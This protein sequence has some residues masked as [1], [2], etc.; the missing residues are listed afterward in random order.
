[1]DPLFIPIA[2]FKTIS[3][4]KHSN[5]MKRV[6]LFIV[7]IF[8]FSIATAQKNIAGVW[9]GKLNVGTTSLRL[10]FHLKKDSTGF[11]GSMDSPDQGAKGIGLSKVELK[12]D[13][14]LME[15][16]SAGGKAIGRLVN[17]STFSGHWVQGASL[18]LELKKV[19]APST[20]NRPQTPKPPFAYQSE[21]VIYYNK[22]QSI[23]YG[24][25]I[26][27]PNRGGPFPAMI[28]IT[29]SGQQ[30]RD[31][32]LFG[33][34]L[35]A[36][37]ADYLTRQG[38]AVLR[39]DDRGVGKTTGNVESATSKD[40]A[41][42]VKVGLDY[43]KGRKEVAKNKI[44]MLGHSE[45]GMIAQIV[46]AERPDIAFVVSL[47][48]P[49]QKI[50]ELMLDQ[51]RAIMQATGVSKEAVDEYLT[52]YKAIL[53]A[54][55]NAPSDSAAKTASTGIIS[56]WMKNTPKET[57]VAT[58]GITE[59][60]GTENFVNSFTESLRSPWFTYF[61]NYDPAP[62]IRKMKGKVLVLNGE[63]DIQVLSKPNL[64]GW[65]SSLAKRGVA[66][67]DIIELKGLN[68]LFQHCT[69]CTIQEYGQLEE[70][71]AP[72]ALEV[73]GAWLKK[74]VDL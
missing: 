62:Y 49:G 43:L 23:Q 61:L 31:E 55:I 54:I 73:I 58:T 46:A 53:P 22:D 65:R 21:D 60:E 36:V 48:G 27:F 29:G 44:G 37:I 24:A 64:D 19:G 4:F 11:S 59:E 69:S 1:M 63:K 32:E 30:N 51:N 42:D 72:E 67:Y 20:V 40:F 5:F 12:M 26:T 38:Y 15:V 57:V 14:L 10:V 52:L 41:E 71:I 7:A 2:C 68:H 6:N 50:D 25:T 35:F 39:V 8:A 33:H 16:A 66:K 18:P 45:G 28:L 74:N 47:A 56:Q 13:S 3:K 9:E 70:T 34:K 17:D